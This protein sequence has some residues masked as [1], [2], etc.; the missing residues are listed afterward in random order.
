MQ[1]YQAIQTAA[2]QLVQAGIMEGAEVDVQLLLCFSLSISRTELL[3]RR[4][5]TLTAVEQDTFFHLIKRRS[6]REPVAYITGHQE[7][8]SLDF[9]VNKDVLIPRPETEFL[10]EQVLAQSDTLLSETDQLLDMCTGSGV[11]AVVLAKELGRDIVA[12]DLSEAALGVAKKNCRH[13]NVEQ[14]V[15]LMKSDLFSVLPKAQQFGLIVSNPPYIASFE[16]KNSLEPE[17]AVYEPEMALD[18]G[19]D[20]LDIIRTI[21]NELPYYL[22]MEGMFFMEFGAS[23]GD[24]VRDIFATRGADGSQFNNITILKDYAGRDRVLTACFAGF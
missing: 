10:L 23:Q 12:V 8:W 2:E 13:N 7:F 20:G 21:R 4:G 11:I 15:K 19:E 18:G 6:N 9:F 1:I 3:L 5:N 16:V 22:R 24:Q 14:Q 17:V